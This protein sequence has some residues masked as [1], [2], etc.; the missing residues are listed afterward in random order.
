M[1]VEGW[2]SLVIDP[3]NLTD[4]SREMGKGTTV[5]ETDSGEK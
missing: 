4:K 5:V 1:G 2:R 3:K